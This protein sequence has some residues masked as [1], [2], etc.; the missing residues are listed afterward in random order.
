MKA[1]IAGLLAAF[2]MCGLCACSSDD[3]MQNDGVSRFAGDPGDVGAYY[4]P[5]SPPRDTSNGDAARPQA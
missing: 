5:G 4:G 1:L 2:A 3:G